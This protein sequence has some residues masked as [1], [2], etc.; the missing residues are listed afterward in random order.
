MTG[1]PFQP[2][3]QGGGYLGGVLLRVASKDGSSTH[4]L[5]HPGSPRGW[6]DKDEGGVEGGLRVEAAK[7]AGGVT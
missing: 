6:I 7:T 1:A 5:W 2:S 3:C 4:A